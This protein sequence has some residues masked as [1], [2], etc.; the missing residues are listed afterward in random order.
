MIDSRY[1]ALSDALNKLESMLGELGLWSNNRPSAKALSSVQPFCY[2]TLELEQW[3]QFIFIGRLR[4]LIE[5][6]DQLPDICG[7]TPYLDMLT[8]SGRKI[9]PRLYQALEEIDVLLTTESGSGERI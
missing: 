5:Q 1:Q 3:L 4:E 7:I 9:H 2:D 8:G 6:H